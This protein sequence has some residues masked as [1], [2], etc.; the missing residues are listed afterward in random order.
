MSAPGRSRIVGIRIEQFLD[1]YLQ[2]DADRTMARIEL[3]QLAE[4]AVDRDHM[5]ELRDGQRDPRHDL[6]RRIKHFAERLADHAV[7]RAGD[8]P[9]AE[10]R[11]HTHRDLA[12]RLLS[13]IAGATAPAPRGEG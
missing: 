2:P 7:P 11:W 3:V 6:S 12:V 13:E 10:A 5:A 4:L 1:D 9:V 8:N